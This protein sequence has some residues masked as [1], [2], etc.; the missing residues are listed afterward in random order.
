MAESAADTNSPSLSP[1]GWFPNTP[2]ITAVTSGSSTALLVP[3]LSLTGWLPAAGWHGCRGGGRGERQG[4]RRGE[5]KHP[6]HEGGL[7]TFC[8]AGHAAYHQRSP[9]VGVDPLAVSGGNYVSE[10]S[11][12]SATY[13]SPFTL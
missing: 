11:V 1:G 6:R 3:R 5:V 4:G 9:A 12:L 7:L 8:H 10:T 13:L 2:R